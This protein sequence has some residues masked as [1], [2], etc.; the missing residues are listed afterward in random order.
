MPTKVV[1]FDGILCILRDTTVFGVES[2]GDS[3][4]IIIKADV[5]L[6]QLSK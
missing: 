2:R 3:E 4:K 5:D 1:I 6:Q